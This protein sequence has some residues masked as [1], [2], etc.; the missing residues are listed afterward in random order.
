VCV[1]SIIS[2]SVAAAEIV[3]GQDL[4]PFGTPALAYGGII[5]PNGPFESNDTLALIGA[6]Q[7]SW[8]PVYESHSRV[9]RHPKVE[10][11]PTRPALAMTTYLA[12]PAD[13]RPTWLN[14]LIQACR[15]QDS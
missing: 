15:D 9:L 5:R 4:L 2:A 6:G 10:F 8:T 12:V 14:P 13:G 7:P 11:R 1:S 3:M